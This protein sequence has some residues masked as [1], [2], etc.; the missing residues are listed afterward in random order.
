[1]NDPGLDEPIQ[2]TASN[3][4]HTLQ[5][6]LPDETSSRRRSDASSRRR[7]SGPREAIRNEIQDDEDEEEVGYFQPKYV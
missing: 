7:A 3:V 4:V 5:D 6:R 1:M 2:N